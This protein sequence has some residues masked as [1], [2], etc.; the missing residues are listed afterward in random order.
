M[1][2]SGSEFDGRGNRSILIRIDCM[3][4]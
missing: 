4:S 2:R 1:E 3:A